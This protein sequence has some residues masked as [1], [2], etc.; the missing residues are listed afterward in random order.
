M[1]EF[2]HPTF[3]TIHIK[4]IAEKKDHDHVSQF[5][6]SHYAE[7]TLSSATLATDDQI[8][9]LFNDLPDNTT[10]YNK[11]LYGIFDNEE[12][13]GIIDWIINTPVDNEALIHTFMLQKRYLK[14]GLA[15]PLYQALEQMAEETGC[16]VIKLKPQPS[17][18]ASQ[19]WQKENFVTA[20]TFDTI[21]KKLN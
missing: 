1:K 11:N 19:F 15:Q 9:Y 8:N 10:S 3:P 16:E 6:K 4:L 7:L 18:I 12:L 2:S 17:E 14:E 21:E 13:I 5:L 20:E